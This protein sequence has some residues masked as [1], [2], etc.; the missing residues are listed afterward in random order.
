MKQ[1]LL[2]C[3]AVSIGS[4][5]VAGHLQSRQGWDTQ[6]TFWS[7]GRPN[8][9]GYPSD[10]GN[11]GYSR[12]WGNDNFHGWQWPGHNGGPDGGAPKVVVP[13][14]TPSNACPPV[15]PDFIGFAFEEA[16]LTPY[17][18]TRDGNPNQF[19]LNLMRSI[20]SRT[21]GKP[22]I[23]PGGTSADYGRY[24][25]SQVEPA[26]PIAEVYT[27]QD[28]GG[29]SIGP[30]Y[31]DLADILP[32][33]VWIIQ[34]PMAHT[35]VSES[36]L[37]AKT[38][39]ERIGLDRIQAFEPGNEPDLYPVGDLGPPDY[40][41]RMTN[42]TYTGNYTMYVEA[43]KE[44]LDLPDEP[45]FQ[46]FDTAAHLGDD[47]LATGYILD[48]ETN[49]DLGINI[50]NNI[51]QVASHY[52]QTNGGEYEDLGPGLMN[53]TAIAFRLDLLR[54]FIDYLRE[55]HPSIPYIISEVG[56]SLNPTHTYDY[57]ATLGSAL[58]QV[59]FQ[60]YAM[61]IG[62]ARINWQQIMHSGY[63]MWLPVDSGDFS[64]RV[65]SNFYAM[66][67]VADFIGNNGGQTQAAQLNTGVDNV[68]AYVAFVDNMPV[69]LAVVN[70]DIWDKGDSYRR[71]ATKLTIR[72]PEWVTKVDVDVLTSP[73]GAHA[74]G[75]SMSYAG[76]QWTSESEGT[77]V[78]G[79]RDDSYALKPRHGKVTLNVEKSSA[80]LLHLN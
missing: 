6:S 69:R 45:W 56:N 28:I 4:P 36:V 31:W 12:G 29:T 32:E 43:I 39:A 48:V 61:S 65:Y 33:A 54:K 24:I 80:V 20:L 60:L 1:D 15:D 50:D 22:I 49:F 17:L 57:Q 8:H 74:S 71:P 26:L 23:R 34:L 41:G 76:S 59:D 37:W 58:W 11:G 47:V 53:H 75:D 27:Y 52:Y 46:A 77:E 10:R 18:Q 2:F 55:N 63:D 67:F 7:S 79:V 5:I 30:A 62:I 51:K 73:D 40:Q 78:K 70:L 13:S 9:G 3:F 35:N 44:A 72:L 25:P 19:S 68:I 16:S 42:E 64:R 66:P 21:G 14:S 38:A